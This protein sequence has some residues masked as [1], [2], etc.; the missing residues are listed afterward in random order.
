MYAQYSD[1]LKTDTWIFLCNTMPFPS[2][3]LFSLTQGAVSRGKYCYTFMAIVRY[4]SDWTGCYNKVSVRE[5]G[6]GSGTAWPNGEP[7]ALTKHSGLQKLLNYW[8]R[9]LLLVCTHWITYRTSG[10]R[11][12]NIFQAFH[13][14]FVAVAIGWPHILIWAEPWGRVW[15]E[16]PGDDYKNVMLYLMWC[17]CNDKM[18]K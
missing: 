8:A 6:G 3:F 17:P 12:I 7:S 2:S 14:I 5:G 11:L 15:Y 1:K 13:Y 9:P 18:M 16:N 10:L 4:K